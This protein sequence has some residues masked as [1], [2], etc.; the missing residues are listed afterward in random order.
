RLGAI[1]APLC[2]RGLN[3]LTVTTYGG[4][5]LAALARTLGLQALVEAMNPHIAGRLNLVNAGDFATQRGIDLQHASHSARR[6]WYESVTVR[7]ERP[8][9][10]HEVEGAVFLDGRP[11][12]LAIDG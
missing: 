4:E 7:I 6:E 1:L 8:D 9:K 2:T 3:R 10:A 11:R 5:N 12:V